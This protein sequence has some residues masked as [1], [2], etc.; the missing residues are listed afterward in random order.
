MECNKEEAKRAMDIAE[1]KLSE[2]DYNGAKK[3]IN[4][5]QNLYPKLDGLKQVLMMINVYISASNKEGGESDWYGILGVDPLA[6]DETVKK[7]YKNLALLLHP[8][9]NRFN[10]AEGAFK[11][12]LDAWTLL[13][14]KAKRIA[15]DQ[16]RKPKQE[17]SEPASCNK[18]AE[19]DSPSS[20]SKPVDVTFSTVCNRCTTR[21]CQF[22]RKNNLDKTFP[23]PNCGQ[24]SVTTN[25]STEVINGRVFVRFSVS[26]QQE[27]QSS[28]N[29][30]ATSKR[31]TRDDDANSTHEAQ[32]LFKKPMTTT[33]GD[34]N[35][36]HEAQRLFKN[37]MTTTTRD[38]NSTCEAQRLF[39]NPMTTTT[40]DANS[41]CEAQRLFKKPMTT[42]T[43]DANSTHEAQRLFKNP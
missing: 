16:K 28:S 17:K 41:T 33:T 32:T 39:K 42:T 10:G 20:S 7:H 6:D 36:T 23:C 24:D 26:P 40:R 9:K 2:N 11:L 4:K 27:E 25:M 37:P 43:G 14:D 15:Y 34:A 22:S 3:F 12:V 13:S 18:P 29:S 19:P 30:Q 38:A 8:D 31:S 5:A 1:R 21:Y 35:S